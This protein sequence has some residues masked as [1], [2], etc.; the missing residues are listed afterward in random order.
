M[1]AE[2]NGEAGWPGE[3]GDA[4]Y[5]DAGLD[6]LDRQVLDAEGVPVGKVD[7]LRFHLPEDG[8]PPQLAALL[9]GPQAFGRRLGG[10]PGRWWT[11]AAALLSGEPDAV[12]VPLE[13]IAELG[14]TV[15]LDGPA[16]E[17]AGLG[18]AERWLRRHFVGRLPGA[19]RASG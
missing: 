17:F 2:E 16:D 14:V 18:R 1:S 6:L 11:G 5:L 19:G 7:D 8:G 12:D 13:R 9:I 15:R 3:A 10:R 4:E